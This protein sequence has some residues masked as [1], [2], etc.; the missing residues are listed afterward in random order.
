MKYTTLETI[1][2]NDFKWP[3]NQIHVALVHEGFK[4]TQTIF[5]KIP[6]HVE[7]ICINQLNHFTQSLESA[8]V[9]SAPACQV[10]NTLSQNAK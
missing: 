1:I 3:A 9:V 10:A 2:H 6:I 4:N 8:F 7:I 5:D